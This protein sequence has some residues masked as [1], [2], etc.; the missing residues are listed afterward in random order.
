MTTR[1]RTRAFLICFVPF[2]VLLGLSFWMI[3]RMVQSTVREG[4]RASLGENQLAI[5]R[6]HAK[7][8]LQNS[9]FLKIAGENPALKAGMELLV[10]TNEKESARRTVEAR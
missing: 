4:L 7:G 2:A 5:A 8:E 9:R 6:L 10:S 1:F 3:Q